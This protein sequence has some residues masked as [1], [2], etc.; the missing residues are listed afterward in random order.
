MMSLSLRTSIIGAV[1]LGA[2][3]LNIA[4]ASP[5]LAGRAQ[6]KYSVEELDK[7][8]DY[9]VVGGGTSGLV[10]A[11]RLS[12]D[13]SM[14]EIGYIADESCIWMP[15]N[16]VS[17]PNS[18]CA[19][20]RFNISS[21]PQTEINDLVY[22]YSIGAVVGGSSAVNGMVFDRGAKGDY[23]AWEELGNPGWGWDG[24]FPY[25]QKSVGFTPPSESDREQFEYTWDERAWGHG[26][27]QA[28]FPPFQWETLK[29]SWSAWE[30]MHIP[31]P[32]EH[33]LGD[34]IGRFWV[35]SSEH[36]I[37]RTR[38]YSRYA[39]YDPIASRPNYHLL[40]GHKVKKLVLSTAN[41]VDGV[42]F[43][44]RDHPD[45]EITL[46]A[47]KEVVLAAG[48]VHTPQILQLSGIGPRAVLETAGIDVQV[49]APGVGNNFQDHPQ[50]YLV[51]NFTND[52][53]PNPGTLANNATFRA[54][55][56]AQYDSNKT[57]PLT[58]ALNSAFVFLPL[59]T[60]HSSPSSFHRALSSQ[61]PDAFLAPNLP[62]PVLAGYQAQK[63]ILSRLYQSAH[64]AV[65]ESPFGGAC[66]RGL[67]LQK[68]LSRGH[69]H[70]NASDPYGE[71]E[72]DFRAYTNPLDF[73]QAIESIKYTR[74]YLRNSKFAPLVPVESAPGPNVTDEDTGGLL[75]YV[76]STAGP[77]SFH[78]SGTAAMLPT[79][80]GGVVG[81]DLKVYGV[82]GVSVVDASL[83]PLIPST[84]L[85]ATVYA[86][87][88]KV[89][90]QMPA[91]RCKLT[92][93]QAA[94]IIKGRA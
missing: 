15:L 83:I 32:K 50:V 25:F 24:L 53:W 51:C 59:D 18:A 12:E 2:A 20:H 63:R 64:A 49:D 41:S 30:D 42:V 14:I 5:T 17:G 78:A 80:L 37:N 31:L 16:T 89:R 84:H 23:D 3:L 55:A 9:V 47:K 71:P 91:W 65:Y 92:R 57:G 74:R 85:S 70:I 94:D 81:S 54:E 75:A 38:S 61:A 72:V 69:I 88:E 35:S 60:I 8:Y 86:V 58:L 90:L 36:P 27:V 11:N 45:E 39:Y 67:L 66:T 29:I 87:A 79:E 76:R 73:D 26:P 56:Q 7:S 44:Q 48:A 13:P 68:P 82:E 40:V 93:M 33:A 19:K 22:R 21:V 34:A 10:V 6:V 52:V 4:N 28:S 62:P 1:W 43:Y 46:K 77:T